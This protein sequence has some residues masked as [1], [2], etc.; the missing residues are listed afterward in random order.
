MDE[1]AYV[2]HIRMRAKQY[3]AELSADSITQPTVSNWEYTKLAL[4]PYTFIAMCDAWLEKQAA[5]QSE[6]A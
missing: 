5:K 1:A 6:D 3:L 2:E 4:S